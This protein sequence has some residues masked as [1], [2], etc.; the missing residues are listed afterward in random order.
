VRV[1]NT[2]YT[3]KQVEAMSKG[4]I[5]KFILGQ[6]SRSENLPTQTKLTKESLRALPGDISSR[7]QRE[8]SKV[9]VVKMEKNIVDLVK[10]YPYTGSVYKYN[11]LLHYP[12]EGKNVNARKLIHMTKYA[13]PNV[14]RHQ[15]IR[16]S[17]GIHPRGSDYRVPGVRHIPDDKMNKLDKKMEK[18]RK[19][20]N[21]TKDLKAKPTLPSNA[22]H[23]QLEKLKI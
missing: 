2:G 14:N 13:R 3:K 6:V 4:N 17:R 18:L 8:M 10:T 19:A 15:I 22:L 16:A 23:K 1:R 11:G 7:I 12:N 21:M 20:H 5:A 9:N